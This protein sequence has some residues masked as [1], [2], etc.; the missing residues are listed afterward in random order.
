MKCSWCIYRRTLW[1][2]SVAVGNKR[3]PKLPPL[4][5]STP[6]P[7]CWNLTPFL[8]ELTVLSV[9]RTTIW[10][11]CGNLNRRQ[12]RV[13]SIES[14]AGFSVCAGRIPPFTGEP[15]DAIY[16]FAWSS[17]GLRYVAELRCLFFWSEKKIYITTQQYSF[18]EILF[19]TY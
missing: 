2:E 4:P 16:V 15:R 7:S 11:L 1:V 6:P 12:N 13:R 9:A 3:S 10:C 19:M 18:F 14:P 17:S 8:G 5:S